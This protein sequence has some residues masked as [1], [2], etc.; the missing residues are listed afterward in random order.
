[1]ARAAQPGPPE[2][3]GSLACLRNSVRRAR[4][5]PLAALR[6]SVLG[7][8]S[9]HRTR[10]PVPT[11]AYRHDALRI[12]PRSPPL[13]GSAT[14]T[15]ISS[16]ADPNARARANH[17]PA[18]APRLSARR[19]RPLSKAR[20]TLRSTHRGSPS[21]PTPPRPGR[22]H[23]FLPR[24]GAEDP[25]PPRRDPPPPGAP[26][27]ALSSRGA[28]TTPSAPRLPSGRA[29]PPRGPSPARPGRRSPR[30]RRPLAPRSAAGSLRPRG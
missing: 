30:A 27:P 29:P 28:P 18:P 13:Q 8:R 22:Q 9:P 17:H 2:P 15:L 7:R 21:A 26:P 10:I 11:A 20:R 23:P 6:D 24:P 19:P 1:M 14:P 5:S 12:A 16:G 3:A 4:G 25:A